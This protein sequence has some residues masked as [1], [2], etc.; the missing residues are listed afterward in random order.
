MIN[1]I[2]KNQS[3]QKYALELIKSLPLPIFF[4]T[5]KLKKLSA[6]Y[7]RQRTLTLTTYPQAVDFYYLKEEMSVHAHQHC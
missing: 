3:R 6:K 5:N 1:L 4:P 7:D 2:P